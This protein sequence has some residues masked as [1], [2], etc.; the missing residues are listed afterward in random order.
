MAEYG[1]MLPRGLPMLARLLQSPPPHCEVRVPAPELP[2]HLP[3]ISAADLAIFTNEG[4]KICGIQADSEAKGDEGAAG[5]PAPATAAATHAYR[6]VRAVTSPVTEDAALKI[7]FGRDSKAAE[8]AGVVRLGPEGTREA[9]SAGFGGDAREEEAEP[10]AP[11][12]SSAIV[13]PAAEGAAETPSAASAGFTMAAAAESAH[14]LALAH[15]YAEQV[16]LSQYERRYFMIAELELALLNAAPAAATPGH[17]APGEAKCAGG[18]A[19]TSAIDSHSLS[20]VPMLA[21]S[22]AASSEEPPAA[23]AV[24]TAA[25]AK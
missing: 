8:G 10:G 17:A 1:R 14:A 20:L 23:D 13:N 2:L 15:E 19:I 24:D 6:A 16:F 7:G 22:G 9:S 21:L 18:S 12:A 4:D 11:S 25:R 3:A 5:A